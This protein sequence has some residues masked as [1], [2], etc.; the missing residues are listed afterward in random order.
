[1]KELKKL[2]ESEEA[3]YLL[4]ELA[5]LNK[6]IEAKCYTIEEQEIKKRELKVGLNKIKKIIKGVE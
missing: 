4:N 6:C 1:M 5:E 3:I 2:I